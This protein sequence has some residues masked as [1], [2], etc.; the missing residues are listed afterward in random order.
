MKSVEKLSIT[1]TSEMVRTIRDKVGSGNYSSNS[2]VIREAL[3]GRMEVSRLKALKA[4]SYL[5]SFRK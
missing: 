4:H 5:N 3:G 2:E 1:F